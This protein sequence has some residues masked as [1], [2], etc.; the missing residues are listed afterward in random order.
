MEPKDKV[1]DQ[2]QAEKT[3]AP[4]AKKNTVK[5]LHDFISKL[6]RREKIVAYTTGVFY[7]AFAA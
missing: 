2:P 6:S 5:S 4:E 3:P 1:Q 7:R